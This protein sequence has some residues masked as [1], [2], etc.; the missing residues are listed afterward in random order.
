MRSN[1]D[2]Q[3]DVVRLRLGVVERFVIPAWLAIFLFYPGFQALSQGDWPINVLDALGFLFLPVAVFV[4]ANWRISI[5][6]DRRQLIVRN[7]LR[8]RIIPLSEVTTA[9]GTY[10]GLI[11]GRADGRSVTSQAVPKYNLSSWMKWEDRSDRISAE[12]LRRAEAARRGFATP[13]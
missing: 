3:A 2:Y 7:I 12:I 5:T 10:N 13:S 11:I 4:L 6:L 1:I 8:T 9:A